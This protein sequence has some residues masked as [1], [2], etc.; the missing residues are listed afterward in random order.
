[1]RRFFEACQAQWMGQEG[2]PFWLKYYGQE[3]QA[4][5]FPA[6]TCV[7]LRAM[8]TEAG[9]PRRGGTDLRGSR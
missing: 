8:L 9:R 1:M 2:A 5:L 4:L 3:D 6:E 7:R